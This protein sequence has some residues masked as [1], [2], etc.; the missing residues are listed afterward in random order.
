MF[1]SQ[2]ESA[3]KALKN[4]EKIDRFKRFFKT[5]PGQYGEGDEFFGLTLPQTHSIEQKYWQKVDLID[6]KKLLIHPV[7]E[8]RTLAIMFLVRQFAKAD[9]PKQKQIYDFYLANT[10]RINNWDLVDISAGKIV[11]VYLL[12]KPRDILYK[13]AKSKLVWDRRI[14]IISTFAFIRVNQLKDTI[15]ISENL[16]KDKHDLIHKAVGWMLREVGKRDLK[17]LTTF[18]DQHAPVMP[19]TALRYAIEKLPEPQ[20]QHYLHL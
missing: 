19:R 3:L 12:D 8:F 6:I 16:L 15:K 5:G 20:R 11:G 10:A 7:H 9:P 2:I 13:L 14:A 18:L 17:T 1:F 4:P